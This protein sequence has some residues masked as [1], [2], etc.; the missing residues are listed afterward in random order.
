MNTWTM[1]LTLPSVSSGGKSVTQS[2]CF[3]A[4]QIE[5][6]S[7]AL[8]SNEYGVLGVSQCDM[9]LK[10]CACLR[11]CH[12]EPWYL[13]RFCLDFVGMGITSN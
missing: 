6:Y 13:N 2:L 10:V 1:A 12:R 8:G 11:Y 9:I 7:A 4:V 3:E 5:I